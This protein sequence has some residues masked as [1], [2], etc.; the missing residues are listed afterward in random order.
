VCAADND[1]LCIA[2]GPNFRNVTITEPGSVPAATRTARPREYVMTRP[3]HFTVSYAINPWMDP[4]RA[5]D[6]ALALAQWQALHDLYVALGH[7]VDV[8]PGVAGLPDMVYA[9]NGAL[10]V[11]GRAYGARFAFP[12]RADE[13]PAYAAWL[14]AAG[15]PVHEPAHVNEGEGDFLVVG[16]RILAGC[17]FRTMPAA[18]AELAAVTGREVVSLTLVDPRF[19]HLDTAIAVLSDTEI[20]YYPA[21]FAPDSLLTLQ[22]LYPDAVLATAEDAAV[23]GLNLVSDGRHVV[24]SDRATAL[25]A[26]LREHGFEP[27]GVDLSELFKGGGSVKCCTL[28]VRR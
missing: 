21:A 12:E 8:V 5:V 25:A 10:V 17:G 24:L 1:C 23:F 3:D 22:Q 18:H 13:A 4:T 27:I 6:G 11:G 9:A 28:E 19:Y 2:P 20:A 7:R 14:T 26:R 15:L 16:E